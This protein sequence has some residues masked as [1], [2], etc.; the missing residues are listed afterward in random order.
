M[1]PGNNDPETRRDWEVLQE[2][3]GESKTERLRIG[4]GWLFRTIVTL[5]EGLAVAMVF[6]PAPS[7]ARH[8]AREA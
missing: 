3:V 4:G 7:E 6:V 5:D 8:P 1:V 2:N